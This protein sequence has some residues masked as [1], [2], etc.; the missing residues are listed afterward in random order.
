MKQVNKAPKKKPSLMIR[1]TQEASNR[2]EAE[3]LRQS[4]EV[5]LVLSRSGVLNDFILEHFPESS[6]P[7]FDGDTGRKR[8]NRTHVVNQESDSKGKGKP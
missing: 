8:G 6:A 2:L 3:T 1:V 7:L 4:I 5:G